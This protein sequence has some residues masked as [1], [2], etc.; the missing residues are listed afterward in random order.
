VDT[1]NNWALKFVRWGMGLAVLGLITGYFPLGHYLLKDAIPSCP[2]APVHG[3]SI[4]LSFVGMTIFG[5]VYRALPGWMPAGEP[6]LALIRLH[7][8]LAVTGVLGVLVNGTI[9]YEA[10]GL[11][12]PDFYYAG[13]EAQNL[14]NIWFAIDGVFLTV[15]A[16]GC[17]MFLYVLMKK[18]SYAAGVPATV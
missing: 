18:T 10:I 16:A 17:A 5:L 4:L 14:R 15:Y 13:A 8:Q 11:L 3:H 6:P 7:F 1:M 9:G 2:T 12:R